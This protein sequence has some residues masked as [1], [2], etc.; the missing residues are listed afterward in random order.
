M[1]NNEYGITDRDRY[2]RFSEDWRFH[3]KLIWEIPSVTFAILGGLLTVSYS[4]LGLLPRLIFLILG[5]LIISGLTVAVHKHRFGADLRT[6]FLE[7]IGQDRARFPLR[8]EEG[9]EYLKKKE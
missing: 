2:N 6:N 1:T 9:L 7:E 4:F 8:S 5:A 3:H